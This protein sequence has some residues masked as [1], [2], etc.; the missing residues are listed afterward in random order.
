MEITEDVLEKIIARLPIEDQ[1]YIASYGFES[2]LENQQSN[3]QSN[4]T[5][6]ISHTD[7][8]IGNFNNIA[9]LGAPTNIN[10]AGGFSPSIFGKDM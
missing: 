4:P 2:W 6:D 9:L 1:R 7:D 3:Q 5:K 10:L 8:S